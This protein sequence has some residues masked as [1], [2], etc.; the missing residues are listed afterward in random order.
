MKFYQRLLVY[1]LP[2]KWIFIGGVFGMILVAA[3][4]ASF[5]ALLKPIMDGGFVE[6][7]SAMIALTPILLIG[8]FLIRGL[9]SFADQ[10]SIGWIGRRVVFDLRQDMFERM[11]RLPARYYDQESSANLVAKLIYDVEQVSLAITLS[12]RVLIKDSL[13]TFALLG[14]LA[15][16]NW[17]LTLIFLSVTPVAALIIRSASKKFRV[18]SEKIQKSVG[19]I[20]H[21]SKEAF[22]GQK[23]IKSFG[24]YGY[25][26][27][28][29][30]DVNLWNR[31]ESLRKAVVGAAS[32]PLLLIIVGIT[33]AG[34]IYLA[35]NGSTGKLVSA[36]TF[37]SY[38]AA[39]I[40]LMA[41]I[42]RLATVNELI[43]TGISAA[44]SAFR[45]L[46][47]EIEDGGGEITSQTIDAS[48]TFKRVS[49]RYETDKPWALSDLSFSVKQ[50]E[51]VAFVGE[52]GSGKS[53]IVAMLLGFYTNF[54]GEILIGGVPI[55]QYHL[56]W[57][58]KNI[59]YVPQDAT[60][61]NDT[62]EKNIKYGMVND[63]DYFEQV[64]EAT[65]IDKIAKELPLGMNT[66]I[67]E[68]GAQL[69]GGQRQRI[70]I[71]RG[72]CRNAPILILD[73]ATSALDNISENEI[74]SAIRQLS[75]ERTVLIIAH[76]LSAVVDADRIYVVNEGRIVESGSHTKLI[77][78]E[79]YYKSLYRA[80]TETKEK[81]SRSDFTK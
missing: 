65:Q 70:A 58:R 6:R 21:V 48:V 3:S 40:M 47:E 53:T 81:S 37:A 20:T 61:F 50:G 45:I 33:V 8:A 59:A 49:F 28:E 52:S 56:P 42:K 1:V 77:S 38:L 24:S 55:Q 18:T 68:R 10:Y 14:W 57:L 79:G 41:P 32:V 46:D 26:Q 75:S 60:L 12:V 43:Q 13:L 36:G 71:A 74:R 54:S 11:I 78:T 29:F 64:S 63:R 51:T 9:G 69:S 80:Q 76:R 25:V 30:E 23:I 39:I 34:I 2:Y 44:A 73:E 4:E 67:G 35:M 15:Y 16:L 19:R 7:D 31:R 62:I 17:H 5:A 72:L 22:E 66:E 27:R